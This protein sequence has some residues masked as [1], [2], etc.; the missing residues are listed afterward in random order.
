MYSSGNLLDH[1]AWNLELK[2]EDCPRLVYTNWCF[3][4][5]HLE[6][7][8][9]FLIKASSNLSKF[10]KEK[11]NARKPQVFHNILIK[12]KELFKRKTWTIG[13]CLPK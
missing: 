13:F 10:V 7:F 12:N 4:D 6:Y 8:A 3:F 5:G 1:Y 11:E 2:Y 9:L